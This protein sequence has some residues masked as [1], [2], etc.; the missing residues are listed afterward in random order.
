MDGAGESIKPWWHPKFFSPGLAMEYEISLGTYP[1]IPCIIFVM[2][3]V[4]VQL[5]MALHVKRKLA[6][7]LPFAER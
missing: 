2:M 5:I 1:S 6:F 4:T 7:V 3:Q